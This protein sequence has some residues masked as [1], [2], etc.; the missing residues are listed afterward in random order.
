M[1]EELTAIVILGAPNDEQGILSSIAKERCEQGLQEYQRH[2]GAKILPTGGWGPHFNTTA[3]PHGHYVRE[4]LKMRGIPDEAFVQCAESSNTIED[5]KLCRPIVAQHG[6]R[7]LI[8]VTSDFHV[9]RARFLFE[10]EF[11]GFS[12]EF[13]PSRTQLPEDDL[14]RR[15][16]HEQTALAKLQQNNAAI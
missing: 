13:S 4:H 12:M 9:P 10:Q 16:L 1:D 15:I 3:K 11:P 2:P 5:A 7:K 6:F 8:V 14:R